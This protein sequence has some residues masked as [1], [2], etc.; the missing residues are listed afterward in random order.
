MSY[1]VIGPA[2]EADLSCPAK[3]VLISLADQAND[4]GICWPSVQT[5]IR[6]TGL[7]DRAVRG[8]LHDLEEGG[9]ITRDFRSGRS[10]VY[11][12]HPIAATPEKSFT[13]EKEFRTAPHAGPPLHH[14]QDT[15]APRAPITVIEPKGEPKNI[16]PLDR[17]VDRVVVSN[18][19]DQFWAVYPKKVGKGAAEKSWSK[20]KPPV[21]DCIKSVTSLKTSAAWTKDGGQFIPNPAT[22]INQKRW[23]DGAAA[24]VSAFGKVI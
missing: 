13:P 5:M 3:L 8:H 1:K 7:C 24:P 21:A 23:M 15:P 12:I 22:W 20:L 19:F 4:E 14:M 2:W 17:Q 11:R 6:R 9:H 18:G 16:K 10:T